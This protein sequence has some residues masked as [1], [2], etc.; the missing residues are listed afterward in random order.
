VVDN[1]DQR[2]VHRP[3][4]SPTS[5]ALTFC[6]ACAGRSAFSARIGRD[7]E[8]QWR[9]C[10]VPPCSRVCSGARQAALQAMHH[11]QATAVP[12]P[13]RPSYEKTARPR[14]SISPE[15]CPYRYRSPTVSG[16]RHTSAPE[17][18]LPC[19]ARPMMSI[20]PPSTSRAR[21]I[22]K[23]ENSELKLVRVD[24]APAAALAEYPAA[25]RRAVPTTA[26]IRSLMSWIRAPRSPGTLASRSLRC[27]SN[28]PAGAASARAALVALH[29]GRRSA[30]AG[31]DRRMRL[32]KIEISHHRHRNFEISASPP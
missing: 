30:G 10:L 32:R 18:L 28:V 22:A 8:Y 16:S 19:I 3:N 13:E 2:F 7:L 29:R 21:L 11:R 23:I 17:S 6:T 27:R 4:G 25:A 12:L 1:R 9:W 20:E 24:R 31:V 5:R 15:S 26:I 14:A